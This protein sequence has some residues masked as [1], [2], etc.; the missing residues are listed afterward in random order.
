[1][2]VFLI[3]LT[4]FKQ[5]L[6]TFFAFYDGRKQNMNRSEEKVW[7][8]LFHNYPQKMTRYEHER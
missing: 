3:L 7:V 8:L 5:E 6:M 1:M 4:Y 2:L